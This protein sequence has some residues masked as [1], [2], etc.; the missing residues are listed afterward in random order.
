[1]SSAW[2]RVTRFINSL[3]QKRKKNKPFEKSFTINP[4]KTFF[5]LD[6]GNSHCFTVP[7][8][9][10]EFLIERF[11]LGD[12]C[13]QKDIIFLID[14]KRYQAIIRLIRMNRSNVRVLEKS[15][16]KERNVIQLGWQSHKDTQIAIR[17][18]FQYSF[19]HV[20]EKKKHTEY[21]IFSYTKDNEFIIHNTNIR[22]ENSL[23]GIK[24]I[25]LEEDIPNIQQ[26]SKLE[27]WW[28]NNPL[29]KYWL[30]ITDRE[31]IGANLH[32]PQENQSG[33]RFWGY[34]FVCLPR[35]GDII[36]HYNKKEKKI[37]S[38]SIIADEI[39][40]EEEIKWVARGSYSSGLIPYRRSG[41]MRKF[42]KHYILKNPIELENIRSKIDL[43]NEKTENI[44][45][46]KV[47]RKSLYFPFELKSS[48]PMRP[49]QGYLFKFPSFMIEL[50]PRLKEGESAQI[51]RR[52]FNHDMK[53]AGIKVRVSDVTDN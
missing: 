6:K 2:N 9:E 15:D 19:Q 24:K 11:D 21:T 26:N 29:E 35:K 13:L 32:A 53:E 49:M 12:N 18:K 45:T 43:I 30:E 46:K 10:Y 20:K 38:Y 1:V 52:I 5:G 34:S 3:N 33:N 36:F 22:S 25:K 41:W 37:N 16:L 28:D 50:F 4:K 14:G 17:E 8:S 40:Y 47:K 51:P 31:D 44:L 48:R 42:S 23:I 7:K 39:T 27:Y